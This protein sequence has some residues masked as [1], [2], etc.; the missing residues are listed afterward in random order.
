MKSSCGRHSGPENLAPLISP[1]TSWWRKRR[2]SRAHRGSDARLR[3]LK[4]IPEFC[5]IFG[6]VITGLLKDEAVRVNY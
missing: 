4:Q 6:G 1:V 3:S 5:F 2:Q